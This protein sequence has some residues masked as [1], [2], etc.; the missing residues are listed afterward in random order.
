[1][2]TRKRPSNGMIVSA[3]LHLIVLGIILHRPEA[4]FVSPNYT[5]LGSGTRTTY[6]LTYMPEGADE[7]VP[8]ER[9]KM[10]LKSAPPKSKAK[11]DK[12]K[13]KEKP[14]FDQRGEVADKNAT[15]GTPYGSLY[16]AMANGHD[17]RPA[18]PVIFP[19]PDVSNADLP[20]GLQ[21]KVIVEVTIDSDGSVIDTKLL[22]SISPHIDEKVIAAVQ[23]WRFRPAVMD[24]QPIP[25]KHDVYFNFP[26]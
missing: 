11:S 19:K 14:K 1:M 5:Q 7:P 23:R 12:I 6:V 22:Q 15:A 25:S 4:I 24:G 26:S 10:A 18:I 9:D 13:P 3:G 16:E 21:G 17:V 8:L 2:S 20:P